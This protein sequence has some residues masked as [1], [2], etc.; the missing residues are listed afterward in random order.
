MAVAVEVTFFPAA[1]FTEVGGQC[2][3]IIELHFT[4]EVG[5]TSRGEG[6][7]NVIDTEQPAVRVA[8]IAIVRAGIGIPSKTQLGRFGNG[9]VQHWSIDVHGQF[10]AGHGTEFVHRAQNHAGVAVP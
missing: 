5:I 1:L 4:V 10:L 8:R 2:Q 3:E 9:G 6:N 7:P